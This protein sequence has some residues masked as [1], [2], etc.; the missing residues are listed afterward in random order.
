MDD[1]ETAWRCYPHY[2]TRSKK[3]VSRA[4]FKQVTGA[5]LVA[6]V[7]GVRIHASAA[8]EEIIQACKACYMIEDEDSAQYVPGFQIWLKHARFEDYENR[9]EMAARYDAMKARS[10][11]YSKLTVV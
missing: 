10:A 8:P 11:K 6:T 9:E 2:K 5:G 1:F 7:E 4:L 3:A